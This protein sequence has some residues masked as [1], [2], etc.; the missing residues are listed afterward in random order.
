ML[1]NDTCQPVL[2]PVWQILDATALH[3]LDYNFGVL[4]RKAVKPLA[5]TLR[6]AAWG[7]MMQHF[8]HKKDMRQLLLPVHLGGCGVL[9]LANLAPVVHLSTAIAM[10][11]LVKERLVKGG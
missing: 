1:N 3:E 10:A 2:P 11:P 4:N 5:E 7:L 8:L 9:N 6:S